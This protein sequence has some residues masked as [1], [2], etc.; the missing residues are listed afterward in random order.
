MLGVLADFPPDSSFGTVELKDLKKLH[1]L[2]QQYPVL[3]QYQIIS[4][5][6][7]HYLE[8][9]REPELTISVREKSIRGVVE[10]LRGR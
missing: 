1:V 8:D 7:A 10:A 3:E 4:N 6:D 2:K 9:I 5:S